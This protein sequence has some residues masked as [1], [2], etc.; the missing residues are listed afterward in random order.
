MA[1]NVED[2]LRQELKTTSDRLRASQRNLE[3][4]QIE[5]K[6]LSNLYFKLKDDFKKLTDEKNAVDE[7]LTIAN[8]R[9]HRLV[10]QRNRIRQQLIAARNAG[11][12][13]PIFYNKPW[14]DLV[15]ALSKR[16]RK[17]IYRSVIDRGIRQVFECSKARVILTLGHDQI[18]F[19]WSEQELSLNREDLFNEGYVLP[20][21]VVPPRRIGGPAGNALDHERPDDE[22]RITHTKEEIRKVIF[23]M[24]LHTI[25]YAAYHEMHLLSLGILPPLNQIKEQKK[26]MSEKLNFY[27]VPGVNISNTIYNY[28]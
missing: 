10:I 20:P 3:A 1:K 8:D 15:S 17:K 7:K 26:E 16:K 22:F 21:V 18:A 12:F 14:H 24:D 19:Q 5:V 2:N 28:F 6:Q 13:E 11:D 4:Q 23:V 25:A 9:I 27:I